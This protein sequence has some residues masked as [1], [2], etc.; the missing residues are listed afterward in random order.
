MTDVENYSENTYLATKAKVINKVKLLKTNDLFK[1][2]ISNLVIQI[3]GLGLSYIVV[4]L[5]SK[6]YN[7]ATLGYYTLA[8]IMLLLAS[9]IVLTGTNSATVLMVP[10]YSIKNDKK[11][12]SSIFIKGTLHIFVTGIIA[13]LLLFF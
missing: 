7:A 5:I 11:A 10:G 8:N 4:Y 3:A 6:Y 2:S 12:L 1:K 13:T 9:M